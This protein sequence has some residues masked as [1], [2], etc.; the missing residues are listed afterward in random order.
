MVSLRVREGDRV[1]A[2]EIILSIGRREGID[3]QIASY[4]ESV[5]KEED[6]LNRI[7]PLVESQALPEEELDKARAAYENAKAQ[8]VKATEAARDYLMV[9]PWNGI[10]S[11]VNVR[12]GDYV[13]PRTPQ[14]ESTIQWDW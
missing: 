1:E 4:R 5:K 9:A 2:G 7:K 3:A 14:A 8:L 11:R 12:E 13:S 6:N 10:V